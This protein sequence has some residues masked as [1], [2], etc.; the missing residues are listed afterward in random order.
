MST[1]FKPEVCLRR[2]RF[3]QTFRSRKLPGNEIVFL[4]EIN[5]PVINSNERLA[6]AVKEVCEVNTLI[7]N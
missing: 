4:R 6:K 3:S 2:G 1:R 5:A 7:I